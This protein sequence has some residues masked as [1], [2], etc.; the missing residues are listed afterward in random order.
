M[1]RELPDFEGIIAR[2]PRNAADCLVKAASAPTKELREILRSQAK[3]WEEMASDVARDERVIRSS[4]AVLQ[5]TT[6]PTPKDSAVE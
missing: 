1:T 5:G 3:M 6:V 4:H 2:C